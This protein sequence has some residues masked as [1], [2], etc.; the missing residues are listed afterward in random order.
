MAFATPTA[1]GAITDEPWLHLASSCDTH[2]LPGAEYRRRCCMESRTVRAYLAI[3]LCAESRAITTWCI[4]EYTL[5][6]G[7]C[8]TGSRHPD[9]LRHRP[10]SASILPHEHI[11]LPYFG[12][13]GTARHFWHV[14]ASAH[15]SLIAS[16][17]YTQCARIARRRSR[18][19][20]LPAGEAASRIRRT[21]LNVRS[22]G[23]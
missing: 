16:T 22:D 11:E 15:Y 18:P 19:S 4:V 8:Q 10:A 5:H 14:Y 2:G 7:A 3:R 23:E 6:H 13:V 12:R 9:C 17:H 1:I 21:R 20:Q